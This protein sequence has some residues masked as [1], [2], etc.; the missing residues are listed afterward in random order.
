M[1]C[2]ERLK[3]LVGRNPAKRLR[4]AAGPGLDPSVSSCAVDS[5]AGG[6][7]LPAHPGAAKLV[8]PENRQPVEK[9]AEG[10]FAPGTGTELLEQRDG[11]ATDCFGQFPCVAHGSRS[12]PPRGMR[13][14][15]AKGS[16][17]LGPFE[18]RRQV[19]QPRR[20]PRGIE[21][22]GQAG[23]Q[24]GK[25]DKRRHADGDQQLGNFGIAVGHEH[26]RHP[27]TLAF[28]FLQQIDPLAKPMSPACNDHGLDFSGPRK[29]LLCGVH[30]ANGPSGRPA[31]LPN[32]PRRICK[33]QNHVG[34]VFR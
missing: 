23:P 25:P 18:R 19:E 20:G 15:A 11:S 26:D 22:G 7:G 12:G 32:L 16:W 24:L 10:G 30:R 29:K 4:G 8:H 3:Q 21:P 9:P 31:D 33:N 5:R 34:P 28:E 1:P 14:G 6:H 13:K 27:R 2:G 17:K